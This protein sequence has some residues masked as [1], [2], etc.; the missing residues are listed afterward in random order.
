[1]P[2]DL[3]DMIK[4]AVTREVMGKLGGFLGQS[5]EKASSTFDTATAAI[6][7]GLMKRASSGGADEIFKAVQGADLGVL[8]RLGDLMGGGAKSDAYQKSGAG[9][10]DMILGAG[11]SGML[12]TLAKALGLDL[13]KISGLLA[14]IAPLVMSVLGKHV[15]N[16]GLNAAGLTSLLGEQKNML[17]KFL[18]GNLG[19]DLGFGNL[20]S[21]AQGAVN[22]AGRAV[23]G[24]GRAMESAG[25]EAA[26]QGG[27]LLRM[28]LPLIAIA[29][30]I[31]GV[32]W[33]LNR[34]SNPVNQP[35][36]N[37]APSADVLRP[38]G[39]DLAGLSSSFSDITDGFEGLNMEN[40]AAFGEKIR[41]LTEKLDSFGLDKVP[42]LAKKQVGS[43]VSGFTSNLEEAL[44]NIKD[45]G[46]LGI[47]RPLIEA[48]LQK[49]K[50]F[51][52]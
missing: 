7:G 33:W 36:P 23:Q 13:S 27:S 52:F 49:L 11:K 39:F 22:Q 20:L 47:I 50:S 44:G 24:A 41:G 14:M 51:A 48:L 34:N 26:A 35:A 42:E 31:F 12:N 4:G 19:S 45:E 25:R 9:V 40:A 15:K 38:G 30:I 28:L 5:P 10:L 6:L 21:S 8:D 37:T 1:M 29:A 17:G 18:P 3:M 32:W 2:T 16:K 43:A 46:I